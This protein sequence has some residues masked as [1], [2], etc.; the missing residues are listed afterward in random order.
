MTNGCV[1]CKGK[2]ED[3]PLTHG[4]CI[5]YQHKT[6]TDGTCRNHC[7]ECHSIYSKSETWPVVK[8]NGKAC[9]AGRL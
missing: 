2:V 4:D 6:D 5:Y 9:S 3:K 8:L 7:S 1:V